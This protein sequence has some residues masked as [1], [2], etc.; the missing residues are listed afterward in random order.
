[1]KYPSYCCQDCGEAIGWLGLLLNKI[2]IPIH[3]CP[4]AKK[5]HLK[6]KQH[7]SKKL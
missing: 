4:K 5:I 7:Q 1:M 2:Y 6:I 3:S